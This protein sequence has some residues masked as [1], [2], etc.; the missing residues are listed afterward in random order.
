[1]LVS[2]E[3]TGLDAATV[4]YETLPA[5]ADNTDFGAQS[6][7]LNWQQG[8]SSSRQIAIPISADTRDDEITESLFIRLF[9]P[10]G[11]ATLTPPNLARVNILG[12]AN[13]GTVSF[14]VTELEVRENQA[15]VNVQVTRLG[16]SSGEL[17]VTY[18]V[19]AQTASLNQDVATDTGVVRWQDGD[20]APQQITLQL[21]DD[22][23]SE[24]TETFSLEL[25][26]DGVNAFGRNDAVT[27][28]ILDDES[29]Q[30]PQA[31]AGRDFQVNA[32]QTTI[33]TASPP[34]QRAGC[35]RPVGNNLV[36]AA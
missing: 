29:N 25:V 12:N 4:S 20:T 9:N 16:G 8:D 11:G 6:G 35:N 15:E 17:A 27:V 23:D 32:G 19:N 28:S 31:D 26:D 3:K 2:V 21:I 22:Q 24:T 10:Q 5:S 33:L 18:R 36:A 1:M 30:A 13:P 34:T 7:T 14:A